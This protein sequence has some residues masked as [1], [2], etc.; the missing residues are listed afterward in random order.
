MTIFLLSN[1]SYV[2][3][4]VV[5]GSNTFPNGLVFDSRVYSPLSEVSPIQQGDSNVTG[6][7]INYSKRKMKG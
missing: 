1:Q 6:T 5:I 7:I 3:V 4:P 2:E